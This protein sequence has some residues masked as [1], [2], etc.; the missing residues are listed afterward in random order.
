MSC[1]P[2]SGLDLCRW[3]KTCVV[4]DFAPVRDW[5]VV[6][7]SKTVRLVFYYFFFWVHHGTLTSTASLTSA[8]TSGPAAHIFDE[9]MYSPRSADAGPRIYPYRD[10]SPL[11]KVHTLTFEVNI[12]QVGTFF[13]ANPSPPFP[14]PKLGL[15]T[16]SREAILGWLEKSPRSLLPHLSA[17]ALGEQQ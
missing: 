7:W 15:I 13:S 12:L 16:M 14:Q 5:S 1:W 2:V 3:E 8:K 10:V 9:F 17:L 4:I 6:A 11:G